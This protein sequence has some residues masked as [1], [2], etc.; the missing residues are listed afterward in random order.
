MAN[1]RHFSRPD[2]LGPD[3]IS[4]AVSAFE[5]ALGTLDGIVEKR[6]SDSLARFIVHR[7]LQGERNADQLRDG[8]LLAL[9]RRRADGAA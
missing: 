7:A 1:L 8:A 4:V 9:R 2:I 5:A 6:T 3:D